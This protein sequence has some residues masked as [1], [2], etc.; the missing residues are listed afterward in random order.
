MEDKEKRQDLYNEIL[1]ND[2]TML[3]EENEILRAKL[4]NIS[5]YL[6]KAFLETTENL[7]NMTRISCDYFVGQQ[8][9]LNEIK[10]LI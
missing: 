9:I 7:N 3:V 2:N 1:N 5:N 4:T 6:E 8:S 10:K